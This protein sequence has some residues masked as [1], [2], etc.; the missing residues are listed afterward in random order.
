[1]GPHSLSSVQQRWIQKAAEE[2]VSEPT[3]PQ[4]PAGNPP[5]LPLPTR[6][7]SPKT[8]QMCHLRNA[9]TGGVIRSS[10][11]DRAAMG[12]DAARLR[13][14]PG[15]RDGLQM[16]LAR[17]GQAQMRVVQSSCRA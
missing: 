5:T 8:L 12:P 2:G 16:W 1:M 3:E 4:P 7:S 10:W 17:W 13:L 6:A 11:A 15:A 14:L 9:E